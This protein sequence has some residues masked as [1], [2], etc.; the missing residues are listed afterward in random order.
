MYW[1]QVSGSVRGDN[2]NSVQ[3]R[4]CCCRIAPKKLQVSLES[5]GF[6]PHA[7]DSDEWED[8]GGYKKNLQ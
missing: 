2:L 3:E 7:D 6:M 1:N 8:K 4:S 5:A